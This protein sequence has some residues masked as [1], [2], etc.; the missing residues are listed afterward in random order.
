MSLK[1][2]E[3]FL[4]TPYTFPISKLINDVSFDGIILLFLAI[5][6]Y[7]SVLD[8]HYNACWDYKSIISNL[9]LFLFLFLSNWHMLFKCGSNL[10]ISLFIATCQQTKRCQTKPRLHERR[11]ALMV[12]KYLLLV[13]VLATTVFN[14]ASFQFC[15]HVNPSHPWLWST[16]GKHI[17]HWTRCRHNLLCF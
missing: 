3:N 5:I 12:L 2:P 4:R 10:S 1:S 7:G 11:R 6:Q 9:V 8:H 17:H 16:A 13:R 14:L 15:H